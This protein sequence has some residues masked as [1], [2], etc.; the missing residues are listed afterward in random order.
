M[1]KLISTLI[2]LSFLPT[3]ALEITCKFNS[4]KLFN[5]FT[6]VNYPVKTSAL[7]KQTDPF[8]ISIKGE[9]CKPMYDMLTCL[10]EDSSTG[11]LFVDGEVGR[12][13]TVLNMDTEREFKDLMSCLKK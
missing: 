8:S 4:K 2:V 9:L 7:N 3:Y 6:S 11:F 13:T 5:H 12:N 10:S 1:K